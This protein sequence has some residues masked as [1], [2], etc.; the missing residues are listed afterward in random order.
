MISK[1]L[2]LTVKGIEDLSEKEILKIIPG[3]K[4][5]KQY[6]G[7][8]YFEC[9]ENE[10]RDFAKNSVLSSRIVLLLGVLGKNELQKLNEINFSE[11][12]QGRSFVVRGFGGNTEE[13]ERKIGT[14]IHEQTKS[15]VDFKHPAVLFCFYEVDGLLFFGIDL[16]GV[17]LGK[18][19]YRVFLTSLAVRGD[20]ARGLIDL[21]GFENGVFLDPFCRNATIAIEAALKS[22]AAQIFACDEN[23]PR[24]NPLQKNAKIAGVAERI[25]VEKVS[26][27]KL[28]ASFEKESIDCIVTLFHRSERI[29]DF[30]SFAFNV[31]K[32]AG[33][34]VYACKKDVL[35]SKTGLSLVHERIIMQGKETLFVKKFI[36][37]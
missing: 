17:D 19:S 4:Y 5:T 1:G 26:I 8:V 20:I 2:A 21:A 34:L 27:E 12:V 29:D 37:Q 15:N 30:V 22:P 13:L 25:K 36:K 14:I 24:F 23:F 35:P 28:S 16:C 32:K 3:V 6:S 7:C 33:V 31:L 11:I 10:L 9:S 18:R